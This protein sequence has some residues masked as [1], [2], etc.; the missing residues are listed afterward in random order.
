MTGQWRANFEGLTLGGSWND[1]TRHKRGRGSRTWVF[2]RGFRN[3]YQLETALG[4]TKIFNLPIQHSCFGLTSIPRAKTCRHAG[5]HRPWKRLRPGVDGLSLRRSGV[6]ARDTVLDGVEPGPCLLQREMTL[7]LGSF[8]RQPL[9][10]LIH[11]LFTYDIN[12]TTT[13]EVM[14]SLLYY[15]ATSLPGCG[16]ISGDTAYGKSVV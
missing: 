11:A 2:Y 6:R 3:M 13:D 9:V 10:G 8:G 1:Y 14:R 12:R 7:P 15:S 5:N 16:G 4:V